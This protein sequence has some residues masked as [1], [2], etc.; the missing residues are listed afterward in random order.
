VGIRCGFLDGVCD[1]VVFGV[2]FA[3]FIVIHLE[4]GNGLQ[5][6]YIWSGRYQL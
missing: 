2:D 1:G 6:E 5:D 4:Q 3:A